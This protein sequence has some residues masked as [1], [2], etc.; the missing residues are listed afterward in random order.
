[1]HQHKCPW[2]ELLLPHFLE[3]WWRKLAKNQRSLPAFFLGPKAHVHDP[4][5]VLLVGLNHMHGPM[6]NFLICF[7]APKLYAFPICKC[8]AFLN[9]LLGYSLRLTTSHKLMRRFCGDSREILSCTGPSEKI[10]WR[11]GSNPSYEASRQDLEDAPHVLNRRS[12]GNPG[13][14]LSNRSLH[15]DLA[16]AK[17]QK[18]C[19]FGESSIWKGAHTFGGACKGRILSEMCTVSNCIKRFH[20]EVTVSK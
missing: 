2:S 13:G 5:H 10:L 9:I 19:L 1:M 7:G 8:Y 6:Q 20:S 18:P 3:C 14:V 12:C 11:S 4:V 16:D 17:F 15:E